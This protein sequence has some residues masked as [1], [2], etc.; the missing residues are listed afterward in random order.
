[1]HAVSPT[2]RTLPV[3]LTLLVPAL[4]CGETVERTDVGLACVVPGF[5]EQMVPAPASV[6]PL[7]EVVYGESPVYVEVVFDT[8]T[9]CENYRDARCEATLD[10]TTIVVESTL[11]EGPGS[12][13]FCNPND[14]C[15]ILLGYCE[16]PQ[17]EAGTYTLQYG[18]DETTFDVPSTSELACAGELEG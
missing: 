7:P 12:T 5:A 9:R 18:D 1:M 8:C 11:V 10:G 16:L 17:L 2:H 4:G 6:Q 14:V 15:G 3:L 13:P